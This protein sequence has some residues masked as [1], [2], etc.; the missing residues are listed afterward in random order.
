MPLCQGSRE[1]EERGGL[2]CCTRYCTSFP[3][4][5]GHCFN[6]F[7]FFC[8]QGFCLRIVL[9]VLCSLVVGCR[10]CRNARSKHPERKL[11]ACNTEQ[12]RHTFHIFSLIFMVTLIKTCLAQ[13]CLTREIAFIADSFSPQPHPNLNLDLVQVQ[14]FQ[15]SWFPSLIDFCYCSFY[16]PTHRELCHFYQRLL[17]ANAMQAKL[18]ALLFD[19]EAFHWIHERCKIY[20]REQELVSLHDWNRR[21]GKQHLVLLE[22]FIDSSI[23]LAGS[24]WYRSD[25]PTS[26]SMSPS[27]WRCQAVKLNNMWFG[28]QEKKILCHSE[29][30]G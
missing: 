29:R 11:S 17:D 5:C 6:L 19:D 7:S 10:I 9:W 8:S 2:L 3:G 13:A 1:K 14:N 4:S 28:V 24:S 12:E 21:N 15:K 22:D 23:F 16:S 30:I 18:D 26:T 25:I 20:T 27:S